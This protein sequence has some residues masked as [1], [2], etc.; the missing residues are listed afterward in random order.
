MEVKKVPNKVVVIGG[1]IAG[2][3]AAINFSEFCDNVVVFEEHKEIGKP[4]QCAEG[5]I[6]F[7]GV[8]PYINGRKINEVDVILLDKRYNPKTTFN[9]KINGSVE[10]IN[11][12]EM[13]KKMAKMAEDM[14]AQIFTGTKVRSLIELTKMFSDYDLIVDASGYPSQWC[15]EFGGKKPCT[16]TVQATCE[17][18]TDKI[19][20]LL[21][22]DLDGY[23]WIFPMADGGSKVGVGSFTKPKAPLR[24]LLDDML[25]VTG[26]YDDGFVP[27]SY[28]GGLIGCYRNSPFV[29]ELDGIKVALVGD[30][31][32]IVDTFAAEGMTKAVISSR[33]LAEC[34]REGRIY[35]YEREYY[36]KM[37]WHYTLA[38]VFTYLRRNQ[39]LL[40]FIAKTRIL[41]FAKR[42][43]L[44]LSSG[45]YGR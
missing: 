15:R 35:D 13:E 20:I 23:F 14:G 8:K 24:K 4:L 1:S 36:R 25:V 7:T 2:L 17:K 9:M 37:R 5:W 42:V 31:A 33:I 40:K 3:E 27:A 19:T 30:A 45:V 16:S 32:G 21:H 41:R 22:P 29:R 34:A 44:G 12:P 26:L 6:H 11:R 43:A 18:D 28:T 39:Y 10:I 38:S